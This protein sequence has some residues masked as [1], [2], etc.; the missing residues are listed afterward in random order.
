MK[1]SNAQSSPPHTRSHRPPKPTACSAPSHG[2]VAERAFALWVAAGC[3]NGR[4]LEFWLEAERQLQNGSA[5][6]TPVA[7]EALSS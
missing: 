7:V 6:A 1:T 2:D 3:V 5:D 4:D